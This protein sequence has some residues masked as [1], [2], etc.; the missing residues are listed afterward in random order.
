MVTK[1]RETVYSGPCPARALLDRIANKWTTMIIGTLAVA[2]APV[3]FGELRLAVKGISQKMLTQTLRDLE[4]DGLVVRRVYPTIP[5]RVEY[6]LTKLGKTL[7][8]PLCA[9]SRWSEQHMKE[10]EAAQ[11]AF[12]A[13]TSAA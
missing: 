11:R 2:E 1:H 5:P 6:S 9:L 3:R 7:E 8:G 4:R 12:D 10:V 13:K